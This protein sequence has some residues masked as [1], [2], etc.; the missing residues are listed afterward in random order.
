MRILNVGVSKPSFLLPQQVSYAN[1][2]SF[3]LATKPDKL[4]V[5]LLFTKWLE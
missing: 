4:T 2:D 3:S 5:T 1:S